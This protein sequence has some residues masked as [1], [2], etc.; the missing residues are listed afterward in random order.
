MCMHDPVQFKV[1][2]VRRQE[3]VLVSVCKLCC[4]VLSIKPTHELPFK[5]LP[6][7]PIFHGR[8]S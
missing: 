2:D 5:K 1:F 6:E 4:K 8:P 3:E 7:L